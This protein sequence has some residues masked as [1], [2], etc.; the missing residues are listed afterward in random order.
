MDAAHLIHIAVQASIL[1][2]VFALGLAASYEDATYLLRP[3]TL[4]ARALLSM[5]FVVPFFAVTLDALFDLTPAVK[6]ALILIAISPVLPILPGKQLKL[7]GRANYVY[8]LLV[9]ASLSAIIFAP[10]AIEILGRIFSREAHVP[11]AVVAKVI[12]ITLLG[13]ATYCCLPA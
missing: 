10:L 13:W 7:G 5:Y 6:I 4:L 2:L 11:M 3:P 12:S 1:L 8:G 9:A